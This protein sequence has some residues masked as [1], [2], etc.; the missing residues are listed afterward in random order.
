[1]CMC[2]WEARACV[3]SVCFLDHVTHQT[4]HYLVPFNSLCGIL[5]EGECRTTFPSFALFMVLLSLLYALTFWLGWY[6]TPN[7][8]WSWCGYVLSALQYICHVLLCTIWLL[9]YTFSK[10]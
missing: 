10:C 6:Y 9:M 4:L 8:F 7:I 3:V 5:V 1:M 2:N